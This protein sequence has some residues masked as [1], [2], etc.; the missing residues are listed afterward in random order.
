MIRFKI[1]IITFLLILYP[2]FLT[3]NTGLNQ[4]NSDAKID[5]TKLLSDEPLKSPIGAALRSA[6][7][8]GWGQFYNEQYLKGA[9]AFGLN[10]SLL[11]LIIYNQNRYKET[12]ERSYKS[13][14][15]D[16]GWLF[17]ISYLLTLLDAYVNAYLYKF[18]DAIDIAHFYDKN[19]GQS[20]QI[21]LKLKL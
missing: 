17:G 20:I 9:F 16:F 5:T 2:L 6:V 19:L 1:F 3:A 13:K 18:D 21:S 12:G 10:G 15:Q 14:S 11:A 4:R 8:P 7:L